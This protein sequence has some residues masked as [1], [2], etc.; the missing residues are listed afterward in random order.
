MSQA[1][2]NMFELNC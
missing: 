1:N 2:L